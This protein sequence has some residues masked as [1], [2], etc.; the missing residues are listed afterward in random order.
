MTVAA[1]EFSTWG[2]G[3][4]PVLADM[5]PVGAYVELRREE[6]LRLTVRSPTRRYVRYVTELG[7][8]CVDVFSFARWLT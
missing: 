5:I 4:S 2:F 6:Y 3:L 7:L 8:R 1:F